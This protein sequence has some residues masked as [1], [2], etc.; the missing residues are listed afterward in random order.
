MDKVER[1]TKD[2]YKK[3]MEQRFKEFASQALKKG[4]EIDASTMDWESTFFLRHRPESNISE[5]PDLDDEYR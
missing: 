1:L 4:E 3:S 5:I 2:H